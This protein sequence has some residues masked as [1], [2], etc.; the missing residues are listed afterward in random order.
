M[1][2][3][4]R[5][6]LDW[7]AFRYISN[8]MTATEADAFEQRLANDQLAR[9]AVA[10]AVDLVQAV[11][12]LPAD[13]VSL[14]TTQHSPFAARS[15]RP[16]RVLGLKTWIAAAAAAIVIA[17]LGQQ[18]LRDSSDE[19][20]LAKVWAKMRSGH[21]ANDS[22]DRELLADSEDSMLDDEADLTVPAWLIEAVGGESDSDKWEDS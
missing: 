19:S 9:E 20:A 18:L 8:E 2:T 10:R 5:D 6:E 3:N 11:A 22:S 1:Q 16:R 17:A 7:L 4:E 13:V 21:D 14:A 15:I 12:D